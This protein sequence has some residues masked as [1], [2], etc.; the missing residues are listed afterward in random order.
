MT[1]IIGTVPF[2]TKHGRA[3]ADYVFESR[4]RLEEIRLTGMRVERG[5]PLWLE[6]K[7]LAREAAAKEV[8]GHWEGRP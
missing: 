2:V 3:E 8:E 4:V 5:S 1:A 6:L 7:P